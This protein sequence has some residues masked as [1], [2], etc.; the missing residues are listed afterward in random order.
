LKARNTQ[1]H[2]FNF[3][4]AFQIQEQIPQKFKI[5]QANN[6]VWKKLKSKQKQTDQ[7]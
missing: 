2:K 6:S 4:M 7:K 1:N 3:N 5:F